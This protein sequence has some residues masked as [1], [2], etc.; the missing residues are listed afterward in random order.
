MPPSLPR[1]ASII[2]KNLKADV[3]IF[4]LRIIEPK[5][6]KIFKTIN[7]EGFKIKAIRVGGSFENANEAI[8]SS[9]IIGLSANYTCESGII[10]DFIKY[11]KK[12][13]PRIIIMVGGAD[14]TVRPKDYLV[15]GADLVFVGDFNPKELTKP[16]LKKRISAYYRHP[17]K[18]L[19]NPSFELLL[20]LES[21]VDSHG[22]P[23][24]KGVP[25][26]IAFVYFTRGCARNCGFC[27]SGNTK[28]ETLD[29]EASISMLENYKKKGIKT[30]NIIDDNLLLQVAIKKERQKLIT[31][32]QKMKEMSF[33]WEF[34]NGLEIGMLTENKKIDAEL[35]ENLFYRKTDH[36]NNM[37]I[38]AYRL[39]FPIETFEKREKYGK[40]KPLKIQTKVIAALLNLEIPQIAFG[41]IIFPNATEKTFQLIKKEYLKIKQ[42]IKQ[43]GEKTKA[44]Y[45]IL[46][47]IPLK[48]YR[49]MKTKYSIE[50]FPELWNFY[51]PVYDGINFSARELFEKRLKLIKEINPKFFKALITGKFAYG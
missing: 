51:T 30:L 25:F 15:F 20:N 42:M 50:E 31:L 21:Y 40:L 36:K 17:F 13:N 12:L 23:V 24:P 22:G 26:P 11:A 37:L 45:N 33:V 28:Y 9:D 18:E 4:D 43:R 44:R 34:P 10:K 1:I 48:E 49:K 5:R 2:K 16:I 3:D 19:I 8:E 7:W 14:A 38:G 47:L 41:T 29:L 39:Y 35:L 46:N 6:E 27:D 32:F